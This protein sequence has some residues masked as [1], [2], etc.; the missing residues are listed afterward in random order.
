MAYYIVLVEQ[1]VREQE[2]IAF[3]T[4]QMGVVGIL[5]AGMSFMLEKP[6]AHLSNEA[7]ESMLFMG[8]FCTALAYVVSNMAQQY[9][10]ASHI[11]LIYTLEPIFAAF[12]GWLFLKEIMGFQALIG[13]VLISTSVLLPHAEKWIRKQRVLREIAKE[14]RLKA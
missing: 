5:S 11:G 1:S 3:T 10:P 8:I 7:W 4:L 2:P 9:I 14:I 12:L 13:S 6:T